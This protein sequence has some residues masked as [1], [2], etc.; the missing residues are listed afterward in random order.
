[1]SHLCSGGKGNERRE[2]GP[3]LM[4]GDLDKSSYTKA[5]KEWDLHFLFCAFLGSIFQLNLFSV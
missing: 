5:F 2:R 3:L 1:V 4:T